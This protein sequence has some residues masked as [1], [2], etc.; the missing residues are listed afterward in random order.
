M[1]GFNLIEYL[2]PD[3]PAKATLIF[4]Q[5]KSEHVGYKNIIK[6]IF[7]AHR[8]KSAHGV[9]FINQVDAARICAYIDLLLNLIDEV[10][11]KSQENEAEEADTSATWLL[12][13]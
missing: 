2:M 5:N 11:N 6:G 13:K 10:A 12:D 4:S 7:Q 8:N 3:D 1:T 9:Y